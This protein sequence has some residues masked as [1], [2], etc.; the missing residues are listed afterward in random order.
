MTNLVG[1]ETELDAVRAEMAQVLA[2]RGRT[3]LVEGPPGI[4]KTS[5]L[6]A[7]AERCELAGFRVLR[8]AAEQLEHRLH[9]AAVGSCLGLDAEDRPAEVESVA[10]LLRPARGAETPTASELN[11]MVTAAI[12]DA[13]QQ[14]CAKTPVALLIDDIQ[15][16]DSATKI[17][18][19]RLGALAGEL[20]LLLVC[21]RRPLPCGEDLTRLLASLQSRDAKT[22]ALGELDTDVAHRLVERLVG[23]PPGATLTPVIASAGGNPFYLHEVIAALDR[24]QM[25]TLSS[26]VAELTDGV[27]WSRLPRSLNSA[28]FQRLDVVSDATKD[29]LR[30]AAILSGSFT[31]AELAAV[32]DRPMLELYGLVQDAVAVGLL[33][34]SAGRLD[35]RH[36]LIR[37]ALLENLPNGVRKALYSYVGERLATAGLPAERVAPHLIAGG[38]LNNATIRWLLDCADDLITRAPE[39]ATDL[40]DAAARQV[41]SAEPIGSSLRFQHTS[42]LLRSGRVEQAQKSAKHALRANRVPELTGSLWWLLT[43]AYARA[44]QME[45]AVA[46]AQ[47]ALATVVLSPVEQG[48]FHGLIA[49]IS[50]LLGDA[51]T[52]EAHSLRAIHIGGTVQDAYALASGSIA[53]SSVR[54]IEARFE[55]AWRLSRRSLAAWSGE[56]PKADLTLDVRISEAMALY[57]LDRLAEA[58]ETLAVGLRSTERHGSINQSWYRLVRA[59]VRFAQGRWEDSLTEARA[60]LSKVDDPGA[61]LVLRC[62]EAIIAVHRNDP[63]PAMPP[64]APFQKGVSPYYDWLRSWA[65]ALVLERAGDRDGAIEACSAAF[66]RHGWANRAMTHHL[67]PDF[68]RLAHDAA[69]PDLIQQIRGNAERR[70]ATTPTPWSTGIRDLIH[71]TAEGSTECLQAAANAFRA[72]EHTLLHGYA[73]EQTAVF[74]A[75]RGNV[76]AASDALGQAIDAY[77][78]VGAGWDIDRADG[79]LR[80]LGVRRARGKRR[81]ADRP[82]T[83]WSA[84][85]PAEQRVAA[86]VVKGLGNAEIAKRLYISSRTVQ[87]HVSNILHKL[88]VRSRVEIAVLAATQNTGEQRE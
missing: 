18:L 63:A 50:V 69:R 56:E 78:R 28:I 64:E 23:G 42:A 82:L 1:R 55:E 30:M 22:I 66:A 46:N 32:T 40:L 81:G 34:E 4:G 2:G 49:Q 76:A 31:G 14:W 85:T 43:Q 65:R 45:A 11:H 62:V 73:M 79:R 47:H 39:E 13:V 53:L 58:E 24:D 77:R 21:T 44:D 16:S 38:S 88:D 35:F 52:A 29:V 12:L 71:G 10:R 51:E 15:W 27:A 70:A 17:V 72:G 75:Q 67:Y 59:R 83:G 80:P 41:G 20:P 37:E 9:F 6:D 5:L 57:E 61:P 48:R 19:H 26:G 7:I 84:L 86:L 74:L 87:T 60:R 33:R 8:G 68:V 36:E 25:V 54:F 3:V